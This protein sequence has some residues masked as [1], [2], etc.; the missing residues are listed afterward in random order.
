MSQ[1]NYLKKDFLN[2]IGIK[3]SHRGGGRVW[4]LSLMLQFFFENSPYIK[5]DAPHGAP[6]PLKNEVPP[7][8]KQIA[9]WKVKPPSRKW[10]LEKNL[11]KSKSVIN[12]CVSIIKQHWKKMAEIPQEHDFL[13]WS[14]QNFVRKT[15]TF[16]LENIILLYWLTWLTNYDMK[17]FLVSFYAMCYLK[18]SCFIKKF[19]K[20]TCW[21]KLNLIACTLTCGCLHYIFLKKISFMR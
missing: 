12:N 5:T 18:M 14:I 7:I 3:V 21:I 10:F 8:W 19:S 20:Q 4:G 16:L 9:H 2:L 15:Q 6:R 13:T 11:E 17:K 1:L